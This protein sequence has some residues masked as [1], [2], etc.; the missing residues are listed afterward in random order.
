M[1]GVWA[2]HGTHE[3]LAHGI[4]DTI[5]TN[6]NIWI[7]DDTIVVAF[8]EA[9][10]FAGYSVNKLGRDSNSIFAFGD[11]IYIKKKDSLQYFTFYPQS[12]NYQI[13]SLQSAIHTPFAN[14]SITSN[15]AKLVGTKR[16]HGTYQTVYIPP[17]YTGL[18]N[19]DTT[20]YEP[21]TMRINALADTLIMVRIY[22]VGS[23]DVF[24]YLFLR[25]TY[26]DASKMIFTSADN[27]NQTITYFFANNSMFY[28]DS[29]NSGFPEVSKYYTP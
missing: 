1:T 20:Y 17:W 29:T 23:N 8:S 11:Y 16:W 4:T 3:Y 28:F 6:V 10:I 22:Y 14:S 5:N 21:L 2:M 18:P 13:V 15:T 12:G 7:A 9:A 19:V 25:K 26:D 27:P 24:R